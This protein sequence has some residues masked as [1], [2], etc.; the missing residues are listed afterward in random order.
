MSILYISGLTNRLDLR[1]QTIPFSCNLDCPGA[2]SNSNI[3]TN[4]EITTKQFS[5]AGDGSI[6]AN[7]DLNVIT[8]I[9]IAK[10]LGILEN[11]D[12]NIYSIVVY[13]VKPGDTLW[14]IAKKFKSTINAITSVN[15]IEDENRL[16]VGQQLF[17]PKFV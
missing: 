3:N 14:N 9:A 12:E 1:T 15:G 4:I 7:V 6:E 8:A 5:E 17:I 16:S 10:A 2:S 13:F 11:E